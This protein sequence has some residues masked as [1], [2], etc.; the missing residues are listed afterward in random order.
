VGTLERHAGAFEAVLCA[1]LSNRAADFFRR[2]FRN[3]MLRLQAALGAAA[4][5]PIAFQAELL[6]IKGRS[7]VLMRQG[8][9]VFLGAAI[10]ATCLFAK[11]TVDYDHKVDFSKYHTYSWIGVNV[12]DPAWKDIT[13][14]AI[15]AQLAAKG[16][17]KVASGGDMSVSAMGATRT[18]QTMETWY[19]GGYGGGW[20][21]RGWWGPG[22]AATTIERTP[23]GTLH[24]DAFDS[25]TKMVIWHGESTDTL[26]G[27]PNKN[28]L[29]LQKSVEDLFKK[30]PKVKAKK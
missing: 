25:N 2:D 22:V 18:E 4:R 26:S 1:G 5:L 20:F 12:Q 17:Q 6:I 28:E 8:R 14:N 24:F 23:V 11:V 3:F 15:D 10:T 16:W 9:L 13:A 27:D 29:K 21:H 19:T 7:F 30:F